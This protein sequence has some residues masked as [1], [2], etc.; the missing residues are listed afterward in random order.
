M[1]DAAA[2][3]LSR[4][5]CARFRLVDVAAYAQLRPPTI[6]YH[7]ASRD[8]L[9]EEVMGSGIADMRARVIAVLDDAA[10]R[11]TQAPNAHP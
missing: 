9:I 10:R 11:V 1:L 5:G 3:I 6:Y 7:Y 2:H 8:D 4:E